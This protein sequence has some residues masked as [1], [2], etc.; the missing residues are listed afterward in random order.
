MNDSCSLLNIDQDGIK[1]ERAI[2]KIKDE[3]NILKV[4]LHMLPKE[5][6]LLIY[7][8]PKKKI[9]PYQR[10][11]I[12]TGVFISQM[13]RDLQGWITYK[14]GLAIHNGITVLNSPGIID[15][16]YRGEIHVIL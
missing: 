10:I 9:L 6:L 12:S 4:G 15:S 14:S 3:T 11:L 5:V 8:V 1:I 2:K 7:V 16:D 13:D